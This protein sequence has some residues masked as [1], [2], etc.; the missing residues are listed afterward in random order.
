MVRSYE[1]MFIIDP[2]VED[3]SVEVKAVE[4]LIAKLGGEV[5]KTNVG[6]KRRLAYEINK[7]TEGIYAV[8]EFKSEPESLVELDRLLGL[9]ATI[10]RHL[11]IAVEAE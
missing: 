10:V 6:G 11:N 1:L 9:R 2:N 5:T 7:L 3:H 4:E 8:V